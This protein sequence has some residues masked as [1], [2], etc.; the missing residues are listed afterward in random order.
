MSTSSYSISAMKACLRLIAG[1]CPEPCLRVL[2]YKL[3]GI[4]VGGG[5]YI[6]MHVTFEDGYISNII[7]IGERVAVAKNVTFIASSHP[8]NSY[9]AKYNTKKVGEI[10]VEDDVWI[11]AG[12]VIL[13]GVKIGKL[14][15]L[16]ANAVVTKDVEP[17]SIIT[18][19]PGKKTGDVRDR[20][21]VTE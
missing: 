8:N 11:G 20:F 4:K 19:V 13:P 21:G 18:G 16:G 6:N 2:L 9:L 14:S 1:H 15:I 3:S 5:S 12:V 10:I 17:Y 7:K